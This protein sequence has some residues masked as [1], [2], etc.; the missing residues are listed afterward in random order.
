MINCILIK[1]VLKKV[2][3]FFGTKE[4]LIMIQT[5]KVKPNSKGEIFI[6]LYGTKYKIVIDEPSNKPA[7]SKSNKING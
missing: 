1:K 2:P 7:K 6:T 4:M 3:L 5:I